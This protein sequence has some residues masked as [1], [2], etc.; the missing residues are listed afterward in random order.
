MPT[1]LPLIYL[2]HFRKAL[3]NSFCEKLFV[4]CLHDLSGQKI[5]TARMIFQFPKRFA[6]VLWAKFGNFKLLKKN[7]FYSRNYDV[8]LIPILPK[9]DQLF[10]DEGRCHFFKYMPSIQDLGILQCFDVIAI[11]Q[12]IN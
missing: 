1:I 4:R 2:K 10:T 7:M 8:L 9:K 5:K 12:I 3:L 6:T 11:L